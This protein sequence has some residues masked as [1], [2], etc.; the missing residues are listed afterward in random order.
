MKKKI[1]NKTSTKKKTKS[2][3]IVKNPHEGKRYFK[4]EVGGQGGQLAIGKASDEFVEYWLNKKRKNGLEDHIYAMNEKAMFGYDELE[5]ED[6]ERDEVEGFDIESPNVWGPEKV[7]EFYNFDDFLSGFYVS[8]DYND[9]T[10]SEIKLHPQAVY[11]KGGVDWDR[12]YSK[13]K[14]F[15]W[16]QD[17]YTD[18]AS[19]EK[20]ISTDRCV[21]R[22]E[23]LLENNTKKLEG[24][25][26]PVIMCY[27][28]QKGVFG[29]LYVCTNGEDFDEKKFAV[30][31]CENNMADVIVECF[32]DKQELSLDTNYLS[33]HGKG[34]S[35]MVGYLTHWDLE[36]NRDAFLDEGWEELDERS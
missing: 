35:A 1:N 26:V 2:S 19:T 32:Y 10:V 28:A 29:H 4:I 8:A 25:P 20:T 13:K 17:L 15:D 16:S 34:F 24:F 5:D 27:D 7:I 14:D 21:Y 22:K 12:K 30:A 33:T 11:E 6:V 31:I 3:K 18:V 36:D 23:L 9:F